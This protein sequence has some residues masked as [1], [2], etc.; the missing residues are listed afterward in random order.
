MKRISFGIGAMLLSVIVGIFLTKIARA[1]FLFSELQ[2]EIRVTWQDDESSC[3]KAKIRIIGD[4]PSII[5]NPLCRFSADLSEIPFVNDSEL[6]KNPK[7][8]HMKIIRVQGRFVSELEDEFKSRFYMKREGGFEE[9]SIGAGYWSHDVSAKLCEFI[10]V[11][12]PDSNSA[13]VTL[14]I[15]FGVIDDPTNKDFNNG[16]PFYMTI[17][18]VEKMT[19]VQSLNATQS[20]QPRLHKSG[21]CRRDAPFSLSH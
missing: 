4:E 7:F 16:S 13:D 14:I 21:D 15:Q 3:G 2:N 12:A 8:Y 5:D 18:H 20:K 6:S 17:L 10:D 11:I 19:A 1:Y 9:Q